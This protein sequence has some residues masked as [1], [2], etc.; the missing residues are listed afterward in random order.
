MG[1]RW[2]DEVKWLYTVYA[3]EKERW[4]QRLSKRLGGRHW[5]GYESRYSELR[6]EEIKDIKRKII[7]YE[8][9]ID[10]VND[11]IKRLHPKV[12]PWTMDWYQKLFSW[13]AIP[14]NDN[15]RLIEFL[16]QKF[17][18]D[19]VKTAKIEK[20]DND[21]TIRVSTEK[22]FLSLSLNDEKTEVN[23]KIDDVKTDKLIVKIE[24][25]K[26]NIMTDC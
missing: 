2:Q 19:W 23:F 17:G 13:D 15:G 6:R 11:R 22:N 7:H 21:K 8:N 14:G 4:E 5:D 25:G 26:L 16:I 18:I 9:T 3:E 10:I 20:I 24:N 12:W 1:I